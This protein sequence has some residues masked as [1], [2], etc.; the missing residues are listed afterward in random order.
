MTDEKDIKCKGGCAASPMKCSDCFHK[1]CLDCNQCDNCSARQMYTNTYFKTMCRPHKLCLEC[2]EKIVC[3]LKGICGPCDKPVHDITD[4][5]SVGSC[6]SDYEPY[7]LIFNLNYPEN[8]AKKGTLEKIFGKRPNDWSGFVKK[9]YYA[10]GMHDRDHPDDLETFR[11]AVRV[12]KDV[13]EEQK[14][15]GYELKILFHCFAGYSRSVAL[16]TAYIC[17]KYGK[18]VEEAFSLIKEKRKY[19]GPNE[20]F[21]KIVREEV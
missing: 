11:K 17:L 6:G 5:V 21:M 4:K 16:A 20:A 13:I 9:Y 2:G 18:T 14:Q 19:I 8:G 15:N 7:D 1:I 12:L 3:H 10:I